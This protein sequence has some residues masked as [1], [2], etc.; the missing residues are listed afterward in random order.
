[1]FR[2]VIA[3]NHQNLWKIMLVALPASIGTFI[4]W[5]SLIMAIAM[6]RVHFEAV[7]ARAPANRPAIA[8][9][10]GAPDQRVA[11]APQP[12]YR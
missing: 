6:W 3:T 10:Q 2:S 12:T 4:F 1:M 9:G 7:T 8:A 5:L 11:S